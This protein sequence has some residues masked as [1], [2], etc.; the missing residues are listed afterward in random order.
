MRHLLRLRSIPHARDRERWRLWEP[1][2]D[3]GSST[4]WMTNVSQLR[5][6][7]KEGD[8]DEDA[9]ECLPKHRVQRLDLQGD[10]RLNLGVTSEQM[11]HPCRVAAI[12]HASS[13][14]RSVATA[15]AGTRAACAGGQGDWRRPVMPNLRR[16]VQ[17]YQARQ[18][19]SATHVC[20]GGMQ[21]GGR[22]TGWTRQH[23]Q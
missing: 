2:W 12:V 20:L 9:A 10:R 18:A 11:D 8:D 21:C 1:A 6:D 23:G 7:S 13:S 14:R 22:V 19:G 5:Q 17:H 4:S 3:S 16:V 15:R